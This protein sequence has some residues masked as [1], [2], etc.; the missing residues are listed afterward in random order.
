MP[1]LPDPEPPLVDPFTTSSVLP[2]TRQWPLHDVASSRR[3]E[4]HAL[5]TAPAHQ[6][7]QRAGLAV[8][9]L[10]QAVAPSAQQIWIAAGPGNNGGDGLAA[11][12]HLHLN[13]RA[14]VVTL[15]GDAAALPPDAALAL[16]QAR[17]AGVTIVPELAPGSKP[18]LVIDALLGL[19]ARQAPRP[20][21]GRA[22]AQVNALGRTVLAVDLPSGLHA[23]S[24]RCLGDAA[25]RADHT[26]SLLTL[27]PG[28]FTAQGR[29]HVGRVWLD[30]LGVDLSAWPS[31]TS[32][33]GPEALERLQPKRR[34]AQHKGSFGDVLVIGGAAGM[35]GAAVLAARAALRA[36]A[37]RVFLGHLD[38]GASAVDGLRPEL[39][40]R[41]VE[42][43]V[44][45]EWQ[46]RSTVICGCGGGEAVCGVLPPVLHHAAR[47]VLDADALN[48]VA[49]N[50]G[51]TQALQSRTG[52]GLPTLLTPHP[53]EAARL[54]GIDIRTLQADRLANAAHLARHLQCT[55]VLKGS[56]TVVATPDGRCRVN[57]T[58]NARLASAGTGD[59]LAGWLGGLWSQ[60]DAAR[61]TDAACA[62]VW[63]HGFAAQAGA[64]RTALCASDLIDAMA[65][66]A[67]ARP[68]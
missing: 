17:E 30:P 2:S 60:H 53:L 66:A 24:G 44:S 10:A 15:H 8:A 65:G 45:R 12:R 51:L 11:A 49:G 9:R 46:A 55:V 34:H 32:L 59:V 13:G 61:G 48:A 68:G 26:L 38:P 39:M 3:I 31:T 56:G 21:L 20:E 58:G 54:L 62:T 5:A 63:L 4:Q 50:A 33:T 28:L 37:G 6:L 67:G 29:D 7:M 47:L 36:G 14:V 40:L 64:P 23:D 41:P 1:H 57:A 52:R 43:V 19:G 35:A 42:G 27:K 25:V 18:D 22:I 16:A